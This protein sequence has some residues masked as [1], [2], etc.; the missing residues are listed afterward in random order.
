MTYVCL[1]EGEG[2]IHPICALHHIAGLHT[3]VKPL[4][5]VHLINIQSVIYHN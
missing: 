2:D 1:T 3:L 4:V 5:I